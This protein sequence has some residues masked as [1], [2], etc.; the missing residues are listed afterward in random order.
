ML[1]VELTHLSLV[2]DHMDQIRHEQLC[3]QLTRAH[4]KKTFQFVQ[5]DKSNKSSS[6]YRKYWKILMG[7]ETSQGA[8]YENSN[9]FVN[10]T[11]HLYF[12]NFSSFEVYTWRYSDIFRACLVD[13]AESKQED[14]NS[15]QWHKKKKWCQI[16]FLKEDATKVLFRKTMEYSGTCKWILLFVI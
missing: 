6:M 8:L 1:L 4:Q 16:F 13:L 14:S 5:R 7:Q 11:R 12:N 3:S 2:P 10:C 9:Q 15:N